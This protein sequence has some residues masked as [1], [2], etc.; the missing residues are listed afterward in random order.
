[1]YGGKRKVRI[2]NCIL[3]RRVHVEV[4]EKSVG[5]RG[6]VYTVVPEGR[7]YR[8]QRETYSEAKYKCEGMKWGEMYIARNVEK[9]IG[10]Y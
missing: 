3:A 6:N 8:L 5:E 10:M 9:C 1:M 4:W 7:E 2:A